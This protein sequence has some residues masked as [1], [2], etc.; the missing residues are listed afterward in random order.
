DEVAHEMSTGTAHHLIVPVVGGHAD[1]DLPQIDAQLA[2]KTLQDAGVPEELAAEVGGLARLSLLAARRRIAVKPEL[3]RPRWARPPVA[4]IERRL[5]LLGRFSEN[6]EG[7][8]AV[9][10]EACAASSGN[11]AEEIAALTVGDDPLLVRLGA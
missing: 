11:V 5:V 4:R 2:A 3:H 6:A 10:E 9:V 8:V 7:D 1:F